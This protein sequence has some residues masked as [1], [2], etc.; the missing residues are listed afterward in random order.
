MKGI[1]IVAA[2][3]WSTVYANDPSSSAPSSET[4]M[5]GGKALDL[6][7]PR[8]CTYTSDGSIYDV[9][10]AIWSVQ[11]NAANGSLNFT[12]FRLKKGGD[13]FTL[14]VT[15][16]GKVHQASTVTIGANG[17]SRGSGAIQLTPA[18]SGGRFTLGVTADTG[19]RISG[20]VACP[21]FEAAAA[22]G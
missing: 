13:M 10:A 21:R 19:L 22:N 14:L 16:D 6:S 1:L 12:L 4:V 5:V 7:G 18:S 11:Q 8:A 3:T 17:R 20:T 2:L 15:L 9:P